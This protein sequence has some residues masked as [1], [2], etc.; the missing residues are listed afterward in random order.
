MV[1]KQDFPSIFNDVI[2]P[3]MR[4][5][6]SS[7]SAASVR[8]GRI[9]R[10]FMNQKLISVVIDYD[11]D[12]SLASTH[13]SQGSDLGLLGGLLGFDPSDDRILQADTLFG[14]NGMEY[15]IRIKKYDT[16]HPNTYRLTLENIDEKH[17][18]TAISTGGGLMTITQI[19]DIQVC[20][21]GDLY[22][23]LIRCQSVAEPVLKLITDH[24]LTHTLMPD[25]SGK[26]LQI[27]SDVP[28]TND[29]IRSLKAMTQP[30]WI[31]CLNPV[32]PVISPQ[33]MNVP[34]ITEES[35]R[36]YNTD[37]NLSLGELGLI[38]EMK[39]GGL[40]KS[41]ALS[42]MGKILDVM[43]KSVRTGLEG[44]HYHNRILGYQS[45]RFLTKISANQLMDGGVLNRITCYVTAVMEA[46]SSF[47][48]IV[49]APTAGSCGILPGIITALSDEKTGISDD[50]LI[51]SLFAAGLIGVLIAHRSTFAAEVCG[52]QA[53]CGAGS[54]M[55]AAMLV[56]LHGGDLSTSLNAASMALQNVMG[57]VCD[58]V[59]ARVEVPCLGKNV[60][61]ASN[62]FVCANMAMSG[63]DPVIPLEE[64]IDALDHTGRCLPE[65]LRCTARGGLSITPTSLEIEKQLNS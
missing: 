65:T 52:C 5:P 55:A 30:D 17:T 19:N 31:K 7:H 42:Q 58:P 14:E 8:I 29:F 43:K 57:M 49:A 48:V 36:M 37:R 9:A 51:E 6:S 61:A 39:R 16:N 13:D 15:Q 54:G 10:D 53:E 50:K 32:L 56:T 18:L 12:G 47:Q 20:I 46:K 60:L 25:K 28:F 2:G 23:L 38:Y 64:V 24:K 4:G 22:E 41:Q 35:I 11:P 59:A 44:T 62:A 33:N 3:V 27:Q 26:L 63:F 21:Y 40:D 45:G 34:F 1:N